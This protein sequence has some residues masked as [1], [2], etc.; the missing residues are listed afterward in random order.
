MADGNYPLQT[1]KH[2]EMSAEQWALVSEL[3]S[4]G[5]CP[6]LTYQGLMLP[7]FYRDVVVLV[8][9]KKA[10]D[11]PF[12]ATITRTNS[13]WPVYSVEELVRENYRRWQDCRKAGNSDWEQPERE[14]VPLMLR[15][16]LIEAVTVYEGR[17]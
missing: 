6:K 17:V 2:S 16:G 8:P 10:G 1:V 5:I 11:S 7:G 13:H 15:Y 12:L 14:W 4:W 3:V 9:S